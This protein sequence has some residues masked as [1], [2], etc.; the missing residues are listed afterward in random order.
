MKIITIINEIL[1]GWGEQGE[2]RN[3]SGIRIEK[4]NKEQ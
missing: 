3:L 4:C 2:R 1:E